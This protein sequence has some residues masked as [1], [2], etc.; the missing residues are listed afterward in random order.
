[1]LEKISQNCQSVQLQGVKKMS[2]KYGLW[3]VW[4][5]L[6]VKKIYQLNKIENIVLCGRKHS[7]LSILAIFFESG[8]KRQFLGNF[9]NNQQ[10]LP[11]FPIDIS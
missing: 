5:F 6:N 7:K 8:K 2:Q 4:T 1:M 11:L 9:S 3:G 10:N